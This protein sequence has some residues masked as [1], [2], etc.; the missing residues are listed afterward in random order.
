MISCNRRKLPVE[1]AFFEISESIKF[2]YPLLIF[3]RNET[4]RAA[5]GRRQPFHLGLGGGYL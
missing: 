3:L 1:G 5:K 4:H 2:R